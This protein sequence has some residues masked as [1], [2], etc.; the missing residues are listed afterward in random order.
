MPQL[1]FVRHA[2]ASIGHENYDQLS[3]VGHQQ[4]EV[5]GRWWQSHGIQIGHTWAGNL[6]RHQQTLAGMG[7]HS[8]LPAAR[9]LPG[10][11]EYDFKAVIAAYAAKFPDDEHLKQGQWLQLLKSAIVCWARDEIS[12]PQLETW[13]DFQIRVSA[14]LKI[15][16][17]TALGEQQDALIIS[18]AGVLALVAQRALGCDDSGL[19]GLNV[20]LK[21]SAICEYRL[22][23]SGLSLQSFNTLPH[24]ADPSHKALITR[25]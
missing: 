16:M 8:T 19:I 11:N 9:E 23:K 21:N 6:V 5:L 7:K 3:P 24:L 1:Y 22:S 4:S 25:V 15:I 18:S 10:L 17:Q 14:A 2:Q 13:A 12:A 20:A